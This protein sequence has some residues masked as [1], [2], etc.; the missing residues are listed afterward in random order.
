MISRTAG[1]VSTCNDVAAALS[2]QFPSKI[3]ELRLERFSANLPASAPSSAHQ[4]T[5]ITGGSGLN[6]LAANCSVASTFVAGRLC[7]RAFPF[8]VWTASA[9]FAINPSTPSTS[10]GSV[11]PLFSKLLL[12]CSSRI[13][14]MVV[15]DLALCLFLH[16]LLHVSYVSSR[17]ECVTSYLSRFRVV[18]G[19]GFVSFAIHPSIPCSF[20]FVSGG[21]G[22]VPPPSFVPRDTR[23][24][25]W[26]PAVWV[27]GSTSYDAN[28]TCVEPNLV[29]IHDVDTFQRKTT[30]CIHP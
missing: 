29:W 14:P 8:P 18:F 17:A 16:P 23:M 15:L 25:E 30:K 7:C 11:L 13:F 24:Q 5:S 26:K 10:S 12:L 3:D 9:M 20:G 21:I 28:R 4:R 6:N 2:R 1:P 19:F 22:S 27:G